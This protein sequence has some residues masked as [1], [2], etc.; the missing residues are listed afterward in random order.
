MESI[1]N[2]EILPEVCFG[3]SVGCRLCGVFIGTREGN[4]VWDLFCKI[5]VQFCIHLK[6][7]KKGCIEIN[8]KLI[9]Y[10]SWRMYWFF[11]LKSL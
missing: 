1:C 9:M 7:Y 2:I 10:Y 4:L 8:I 3:L 11:F 6:S 5:H